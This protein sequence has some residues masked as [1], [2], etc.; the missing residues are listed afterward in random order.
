MFAEYKTIDDESAIVFKVGA[1][2]NGGELHLIDYPDA[3]ESLNP[4]IE[5]VAISIDDIDHFEKI[6]NHV[7]EIEMEHH[8]IQH[9]AGLI[10]LYVRDLTGIIITI[11]YDT[12]N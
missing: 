10:S 11:T 9:E 1:G 8:I 3:I 7:K 5:R 12:V 2:G 6:V 4:P